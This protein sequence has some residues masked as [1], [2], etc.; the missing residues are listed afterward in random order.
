MLFQIGLNV[1]DA[2]DRIRQCVD[3]GHAPPA[4]CQPQGMTARAGCEIQYVTGL[5]TGES[6]G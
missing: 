4:G 1:P 2:G 5:Q 6:R 3:G